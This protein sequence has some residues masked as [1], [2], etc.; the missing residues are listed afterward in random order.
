MV[1]GLLLEQCHRTAQRVQLRAVPVSDLTLA[2][3]LRLS[4]VTLLQ[5]LHKMVMVNLAGERE[6]DGASFGHNETSES[7][8]ALYIRDFGL[9]FCE[10]NVKRE[11]LRDFV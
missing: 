9:G 4:R 5:Y 11:G 3:G 7:G 6:F 2:V 10:K 1:V 8:Y